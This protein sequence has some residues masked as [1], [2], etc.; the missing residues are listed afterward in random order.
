M[1][2]TYFTQNIFLDGITV[3]PQSTV[4]V[5]DQGLV[6]G[7]PTSA[8]AM[9]TNAG[10]VNLTNA[11]NLTLDYS[12][13]AAAMNSGTIS[14]G[15]ESAIYL[16][17]PSAGGGTLTNT[18]SIALQANPHGSQIY[19][20][21]DGAA[22]TLN[23]G[24]NLTLSDN[25]ANLI[26]GSFGTETLISDNKI[27]GAGTIAMLANFTNN[28]TVVANGTNSLVFNMD[29]GTAGVTGTIV[30]N[31]SIQAASGSSLVLQGSVGS[32]GHEQRHDYPQCPGRPCQRAAL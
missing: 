14:V 1:W 31:G 13:G 15:D 10:T 4:H 3:G 20:Y 21:G 8:A 16:T 18:G 22:F 25:P 17:A 9:L 30:N 26:T 7:S 19:L 6:L 27:S 24:G 5:N 12:A 23:G 32:A 29:T 28:G 2:R 11:A